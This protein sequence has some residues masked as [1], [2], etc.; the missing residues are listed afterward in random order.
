MIT[1]TIY[2]AFM[3]KWTLQLNMS[4]I[5]TAAEVES[6]LNFLWKYL[7]ATSLSFGVNK[8]KTN[9]INLLRY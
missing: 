4:L 9:Y 2:G 8:L 3:L 7:E 5:F 6:K 1:K